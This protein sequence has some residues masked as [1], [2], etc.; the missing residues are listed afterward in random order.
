M[1]EASP[2]GD[3]KSN[4]VAERA[5]QSTEML[6]R[7]HKLSIETPIN[8]MLSVRHPLFAWLVEFC[9]DLHN[10]FHIG[11]DGKTAHQRL[12]E[13]HSSQVM[14][15]FGTAVM[16][17]V[18]GKVQGSSM[19]ERW[20][21]GIFLGKK[22]GTEENI[23]TRENGS[24]VR[25]RAISELQKILTLKDYDVL[26]GTPHD[27]IGTLRGVARDVGRPSETLG[28]S[29]REDFDE[30]QGTRRVQIRREVVEKFGPT[31]DCKKC[32]GLLARDRA[33]QYYVHHR[34]ECR[35]RMEALM[36]E[37][38]GFRRHVERADLRLTKRLADVMERRDRESQDRKQSRQGAD[39]RGGGDLEQGHQPEVAEQTRSGA[40][41]GDVV[42]GDVMGKPVATDDVLFSEGKRKIEDVEGSGAPSATRQKLECVFNVEKDKTELDV[43]EIF[44]RPRVCQVAKD[45]GLRGRYSLN[46]NEGHA[47]Q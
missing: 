43:C 45:L 13:K 35:T 39:Q 29:P 46:R 36:W 18:C 41:P 11:S 12:K 20:F 9:A 33:Y 3:S 4:D 32:R 42:M 5:I 31:L 14:V 27:P 19:G 44:S 16:F 8:E 38:D 30:L 22:A 6:I 25:A 34:E 17:S 1:L 37:D 28:E 10:R 40:N 21:H 26:R 24:V 7:V 2:V 23:V 15:E 47:H